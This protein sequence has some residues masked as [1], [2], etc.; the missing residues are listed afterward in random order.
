MNRQS[1]WLLCVSVGRRTVGSLA[2]V[3]VLVGC[4]ASQ[5][6]SGE[7]PPP[8]QSARSREVADD[9]AFMP[10]DLLE[11]FVKE[12]PTLNGSYPVREGG[13]IVIPRAGRIFVAGLDRS[14]AEARVKTSLQSSQLTEATVLVERTPSS[15]VGGD[16]LSSVAIPKVMVFLTGAV[17]RPG[18]HQIP[19]VSDRQPGLY[20]VI[21]ITG[22]L[23]RYAKEEAIEILRTDSSGKRH[24]ATIDLRAIRNGLSPDPAVSAGDV[25]HVPEK[26]FGF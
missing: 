25:I 12:D 13:Y 16:A 15:S 7:L 22:G 10:G 19:L 26:V 14:T 17:S 23:G 6:T 4:S 3:L 24:H 18:A 8:V 9:T 20:E 11:L 1:H 21:L 5:P 2:L